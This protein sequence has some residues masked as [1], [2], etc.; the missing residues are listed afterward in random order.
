M[1][2]INTT[3]S[4]SQS[5][6]GLRINA[7]ALRPAEGKG[8]NSTI[9]S[10]GSSDETITL[11]DIVTPQQIAVSLLSGSPVLVG[12]DGST[13]PFYLSAAGASALF[14]LAVTREVSAIVA[15]ADS[16][17]SLSSK[18]FVLTDRAGTVWVWLDTG[19]FA[20][21]TL[22]MDTQPSDGDTLTIGSRT[23]TWQS[24]LS[25]V[26]GNIWI[27]ADLAAAK[28]NL[29]YAI[30][31]SGGT[32]G[33]DYAAAMTANTQVSLAAFASD[34]AVFTALAVG[35]AANAFASTETFT[36]GTNV[37]SGTTMSGGLAASVA[38]AGSPN[39][40]LQVTILPNAT[41]AAVA[42][43]LQVALDADAEFI[44]S[45]LD[46]TVTV[47]DAHTGTR[48]DA[49]DGDT[50]WSSI[51]TTQQGAASPVIHL[52]SES[53]SEVLVAVAPQ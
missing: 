5:P 11:G 46:A 25:N 26:D 27:G 24:T 35:T 3:L 20:T 33:T 30:A 7:N 23:Y 19:E 16:G 4:L 44:A 43:A 41:A 8:F 9:A 49:A 1:S 22:T 6:S 15:E 14:P 38:P 17:A 18:Y 39:R 45:V 34:D 40:K 42:T 48:T 2:T 53:A 13:Y 52:K 50:G 31:D 47:T 32:P 36:A 51:T 29:G 10:V 37:F 21:V 28:L 12:L